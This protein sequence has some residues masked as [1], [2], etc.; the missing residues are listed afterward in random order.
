MMDA[1]APLAT[2]AFTR[3]AQ[4]SLQGWRLALTLGCG[5]AHA[6][7]LLVMLLTSAFFL[8]FVARELAALCVQLL[9]RC[10]RAGAVLLGAATH[11]PV[12]NSVRVLTKVLSS[13]ELSSMR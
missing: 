9:R 2:A 8:V 7:A 13:G 12:G 3:Y 5:A 11:S 10:V 6:L 4:V 1:L